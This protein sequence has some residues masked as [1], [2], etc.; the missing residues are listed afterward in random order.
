MNKEKFKKKMLSEVLKFEC[1][2]S[3]DKDD[4][5]GE[6]Y[7]GICRKYYTTI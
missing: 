5:G 6:T 4:A 3:F 1:K 2:Y 7:I